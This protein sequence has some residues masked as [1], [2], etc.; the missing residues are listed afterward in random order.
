MPSYAEL[1]TLCGFASKNAAFKLAT[2]LIAAG[3][4]VKDASGRLVPGPQLGAASF[5]AGI[6]DAP[7]ASGGAHVSLH[8]GQRHAVP[9]PLSV[10][11]LG[12]VEAGIPTVAEDL[13]AETVDVSDLIP[14]D[15]GKFYFFEVKGESMIE[16][17]ICE[18]DLVLVERAGSGSKEARQG[19]IVIAYVDGGWTMKYFMRTSAGKVFL[20]PANKKFK[21]IFPEQELQIAGVVRRVVRK[22]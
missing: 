11:F 7:G 10:P 3:V 12:L 20:R 21:D 1:A 8:S 14:S 13:P 2:R 4:M 17:G 16:A 18:G 9:S 15:P 19:D 5:K 6:A 22:V